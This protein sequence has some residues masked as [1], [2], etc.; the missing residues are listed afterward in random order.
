MVKIITEL[1][2][3]NP[4]LITILRLLSVIDVLFYFVNRSAGIVV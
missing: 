4:L 3:Y 2:R 1:T